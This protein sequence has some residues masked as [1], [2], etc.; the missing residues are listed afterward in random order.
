MKLK[1]YKGRLTD[2]TEEQ[3][4][5]ILNTFV[6]ELIL[7]MGASLMTDEANHLQSRIHEHVNTPK[8]IKYLMDV[9]AEI[10]TNFKRY[11][12][13]CYASIMTAAKNLKHD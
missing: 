11:S 13:L 5:E 6:N 8:S 9:S 7:D 3:Q 1:E 2:Y 10:I 4:K 12:P